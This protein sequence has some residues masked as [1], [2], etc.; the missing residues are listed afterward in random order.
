M[1]LP[2]EALCF[3]LLACTSSLRVTSTNQ[4]QHIRYPT[5]HQRLP[6]V[7]LQGKPPADDNVSSASAHKTWVS[8]HDLDAPWE[9]RSQG[10][11]QADSYELLSLGNTST[12]SESV[13]KRENE[14]SW[15]RKNTR[16][17]PAEMAGNKRETK[18]SA[19]SSTLPDKDHASVTSKIQTSDLDLVIP[20]TVYNASAT[21]F[22]DVKI[23]A[24][25]EVVT[26][27]FYDSSSTISCSCYKS[28]PCKN[29]ET[30]NSY[31]IYEL[32]RKVSVSEA[33]EYVDSEVCVG[34]ERR[35]GIESAEE[36]NFLLNCLLCNINTNFGAT[37][38]KTNILTSGIMSVKT[39][40]ETPVEVLTHHNGMGWNTSVDHKIPS[41]VV[42]L[43][44][45]TGL[46]EENARVPPGTYTLLL[47]G[48]N[49]QMCSDDNDTYRR[50]GLLSY[51][52]KSPD[53][54]LCETPSST[55]TFTTTTTTSQTTTPVSPTPTTTT[56][57]ATTTSSTT[58]TSTTTDEGCCQMLQER[59]TPGNTQAAAT[60][61]NTQAAATF[62][63]PLIYSGN[64]SAVTIADQVKNNT[65]QHQQMTY[66]DLN[67]LNT[68]VHNLSILCQHRMQGV[69]EAEV[70]VSLAKNYTSKLVA[71]TGDVITVSTSWS[72]LTKEEAGQ[73]GSPLLSNLE[74]SGFILA[75]QM[76][77]DTVTFLDPQ[78]N[79]TVLSM[80][81]GELSGAELFFP[82]V[83]ASTYLHLPK[84]FES[85]LPEGETQ[86]RMVGFILRQDAA[87]RVLPASL[88]RSVPYAEYKVINS[89]VVSMSL[90]ESG[91][92]INFTSLEE[93]VI[94]RLYHT[95]QESG[96]YFRDLYRERREGEAA[97]PVPA[98]ARCV[99]WDS[100]YSMWA[101]EGCDLV[102]TTNE[103]TYCWCQHLT[104]IAI[105][106]DIHH[107]LG[108]DATLD[109][110]G[111]VL[112]TASCVSLCLA[113]CILQSIK[114]L[115]SARTSITKHLCVT[116]GLSH[117]LLLLLLDPDFLKLSKRECEASAVVL[118]YCLTASL[119][120]MLGEGIH[121]VY[122][123]H[124]LLSQTRY[125]PAY[126]V[127]G[128]GVP[129]VVVM[130]TLLTSYSTQD[131]LTQTA[132]APPHAE[133]CWL[134]TDGGYIW[135]FTGPLVMVIVVN[136]ISMILA[137]RSAAVLKANKQKTLT[138]QV[139]LWVKGSFS[140]NCLLGVT[141]VFGLL[142]INTGHVFAYLFTILT[143]S[144]GV[145]ILVFH[146]LVNTTVRTA[147]ISRLRK[148]FK[149]L[150]T[151]S[152]T[153]T[154]KGTLAKRQS[155]AP[156]KASSDLQDDSRTHQQPST[157]Q[158]QHP[159]TLQRQH[160]STLQR[161]HPL[162]LHHRSR[163]ACQHS[164]DVQHHDSCRQHCF[165]NDRQ[166]CFPNIKYHCSSIVSQYSSSIHQ[167]GCINDPQCT[168]ED[169]Q[170]YSNDG[171]QYS[172]NDH[173]Q[174]STNDGQQ[175]STNDGHQYSTNDGHQY[176]TNDGHQYSTNDRHHYSP[177]V[178][179]VP[180]SGSPEVS[181]RATRAASDWSN[182]TQFTYISDCPNSENSSERR[183]SFESCTSDDSFTSGPP[184]GP[185]RPSMGSS[186]GPV[187]PLVTLQAPQ[188]DRLW[189]PDN[190]RYVPEI[191]TILEC[192]ERSPRSENAINFF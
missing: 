19:L 183:T 86:A 43:N 136:T 36:F 114:S 16:S 146:C 91:H 29:Q 141:W 143:A 157:L 49:Q 67:T 155:C 84:N 166:K 129:A 121:L 137:L 20:V 117:L 138:Q 9:T 170:Q 109:T 151:K 140:L 46:P 147:V 173:D 156:A 92:T 75:E 167:R 79:M 154:S 108:R 127:V 77:Q 128:Y 28:E 95:Q 130:V 4:Q 185:S 171:Y 162:L 48:N 54:V 150:P 8:K 131:W 159:S 125:M 123:I 6:S 139:R 90:G 15:M 98:T 72:S 132:Y 153:S 41:E 1:R 174:Y 66:N 163:G 60:P 83:E 42:L 70:R 88:S 119:C 55:T 25:V 110:L 63:I 17:H 144:Q 13:N 186:R 30:G 40:Y 102:N 165:A 39:H 73:L 116:L 178:A 7:T 164:D 133:Y 112:T 23:R 53:Y 93:G 181:Q 76:T 152:K 113:F 105:L 148:I 5:Q 80:P 64:Y 191:E 26:N 69:E 87:S 65:G 177:R 38:N 99:Y 82:G 21:N 18:V 27:A 135:A 68:V 96:P 145:M 33:V 97:T 142:Y 104:M 52:A 58:T 81:R 94:F 50:W 61:G 12:R 122:T 47:L 169:S 44:K 126:W 74:N 189:E 188:D 120:W 57:A 34:Q 45:S 59:E 71:I 32:T 175:C 85:L 10:Q 168:T 182:I 176:S 158:R 31:R 22:D 187:P 3:T 107:Y 160:P 37:K 89:A 192:E 111:T 78:L 56:G 179:P 11:R 124:H 184:L 134:N 149:Y 118:H 51:K 172:T 2:S 100:Y 35:V 180:L 115:G 190:H 101:P 161:Q 14:I 62:N 103:V 24:G 106:T